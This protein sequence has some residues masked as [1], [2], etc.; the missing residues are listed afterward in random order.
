MLRL[1]EEE[2]GIQVPKQ[3]IGYF[4]MF[5]CA[6]DEE[7]IY[8]KVAVIVMAHG[9]STASSMAEVA[10]KLLKTRHCHAIDM[11]LDVPAEEALEK[12]VVLA[13]EADEGK[14]VLVLADTG[15]CDCLSCR[16]ASGR[17]GI[18]LTGLTFLWN[19]LT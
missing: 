10:N 14:G 8:P 6:M 15:F 5:L 11:P 1:L 7:A 4:T 17:K 9:E 3:E 19:R 2:L 12:A 13:K 18:L 16:N